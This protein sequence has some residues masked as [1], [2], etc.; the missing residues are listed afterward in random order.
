MEKMESNLEMLCPDCEEHYIT[1]DY[2]KLHG[3]CFSC[4][5]RETIAHTKGK[6]YIKYKDLS[7]KEKNRLKHQRDVNNKWNASKRKGNIK[8]NSSNTKIIKKLNNSVELI[9]SFYKS[10]IYPK[11]KNQFFYVIK[12]TDLYNN[13]CIYC[14]KINQAVIP[15][16]ILFYKIL[17]DSFSFNKKMVN[18]ANYYYVGKHNKSS[19]AEA[20]REYE[21]D[22]V[23]IT[24]T[25]GDNMLQ[26]EIKSE[27]ESNI[28]SF[29][30]ENEPENFV[31]IEPHIFNEFK[32]FDENK[33]DRLQPIRDE[34]MNVLQNK[35]KTMGCVS[36]ND[37]LIE[38][39]IK[40]F[41][42]INY[43]IYN[44]DDLIKMRNNQ[45]DITNMYK[46]DVIHEMENV[47][48]DTGDTYL[49]D[50]MHVLRDVR[51][52]IESDRDAL[53]QL[54]GF[55]GSLK[56]VFTQNK[57]MKV[58]NQLKNLDE[59]IKQPKFI[60]TVDL[61]MISKYQWATLGTSV[62]VKN[63]REILVTNDLEESM[64][65]D[66]EDL[67]ITDLRSSRTAGDG[68]SKIVLSKEDVAKGLGIYRVSCDISGGGFGAFRKWYKD[69][70]CINE[71]IALSFAQTEFGK[72]KSSN[73]NIL[74]T[75]VRVSK[76]NVV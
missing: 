9:E 38:D 3:K 56:G 39:Y 76:L 4:G 27:A 42:T 34:V 57:V 75:S 33:S 7:D 43:L 14:R 21:N 37:Y 20:V 70:P 58:V 17:K 18:G 54:K 31:E 48:S 11:L 45:Y 55:L 1:K 52:Y 67:V 5:R 51:R 15:S 26:Q 23:P 73:K 30:S 40:A 16:R 6:E 68:P 19:F 22:I 60:P 24:S 8:T 50:K 29:D 49:Q 61:N 13:F 47:L 12:S 59:N 74:I 72:M 41:T 28:K 36:K 62:S 64:N 69:Y 10:E 65:K 66:K 53:K 71:K 44:V 2:Y 32:K 35:F 46:D 25:I 63:K